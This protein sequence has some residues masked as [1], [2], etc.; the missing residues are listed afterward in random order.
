[1]RKHKDKTGVYVFDLVDVFDYAKENYSLQHF[2]E[3]NSYY[4]FEEIP[5]V[6]KEIYL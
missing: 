2:W 1:M 4:D 6:E 3:R 5:L